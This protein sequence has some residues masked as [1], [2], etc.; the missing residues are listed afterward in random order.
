MLQLDAIGLRHARRLPM[1]QHA[2]SSAAT[3]LDSNAR[4]AGHYAQR[5]HILDTGF[6]PH[7]VAVTRNSKGTSATRHSVHTERDDGARLPRLQ[8]SRPW[9]S[10]AATVRLDLNLHHCQLSG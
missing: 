7:T 10:W 6:T 9:Q 3:A 4:A 1:L 5:A 2:A 8:A